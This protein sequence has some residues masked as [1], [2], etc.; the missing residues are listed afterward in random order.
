MYKRQGNKEVTGLLFFIAL[1]IIIVAAINFTNFSTSLTPM[2]IR[3]INTQKVLGSSDAVLRCAL[4]VE[5]AIISM[6]AW[7]PVSYTHLVDLH[8]RFTGANT[9][10]IWSISV[11]KPT[12][13]FM[14]I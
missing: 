1:L 2:R 7:V 4:L 3:S 6:I 11:L 14:H 10:V 13:I 12:R 8:W 5:A 9:E